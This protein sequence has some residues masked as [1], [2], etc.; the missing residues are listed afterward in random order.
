MDLKRRG[1]ETAIADPHQDGCIKARLPRPVD[2]T[3]IVTL[4]S[5]GGIAGGDRV[6][7]KLRD[8]QGPKVAPCSEPVSE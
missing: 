8:Y 3:E 4:N 1:T 2:W 7:T 6:S 5:S